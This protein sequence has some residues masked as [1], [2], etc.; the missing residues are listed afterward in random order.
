MIKRIGSAARVN[1]EKMTG[2]KVYL[3]IHVK[4][5]ED[6]KN[7]TAYLNDLGYRKGEH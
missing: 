3:E 5:R 4:V 2:C 1:I 6:W 7:R